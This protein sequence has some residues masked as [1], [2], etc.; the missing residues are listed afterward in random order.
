MLEYG[1]EVVATCVSPRSSTGLSGDSKEAHVLHSLR[2]S[3]VSQ[4][5]G[6][7]LAGRTI[8]GLPA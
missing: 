7:N 6:N 8:V 2:D 1:M 3:L 4:T 5:L